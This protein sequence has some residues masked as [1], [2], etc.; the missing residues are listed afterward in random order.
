M[1]S[2]AT[3]ERR[4]L[5]TQVEA[6]GY[7]MALLAEVSAQL[8]AAGLDSDADAIASDATT[9]AS[10]RKRVVDLLAVEIAMP[11]GG[12]SSPASS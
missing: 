3:F 2:G 9:L 12:G 11:D 10:L 4:V 7:G 5:L 6:L 8:R 1:S